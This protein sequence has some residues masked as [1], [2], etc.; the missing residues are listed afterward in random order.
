MLWGVELFIALF[1]QVLQSF[2][3]GIQGPV[4]V[5]ALMYVLSAAA[6]TLLKVVDELGTCPA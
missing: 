2:T 3:P 6:S 1:A 5:P 4:G